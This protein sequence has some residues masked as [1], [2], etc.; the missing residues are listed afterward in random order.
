MSALTLW[1]GYAAAVT[2]TLISVPQAWRAFRVGTA[3]VSAVTFQLFS[4]IALMWMAYGIYEN[5]VPITL[6][7]GVQFLAC[8]AVL[9]ACRRGGAGW[10]HLV[11]VALSTAVLAAV[12][13]LVFGIPAMIWM[14]IAV[15]VGLRMP[16]LISALTER[17]V[18]GIS[19][20]TWW[21]AVA[22]NIFSFA[23]GLGNHDPR[24]MTACILNG[25]SSYAIILAVQI[26]RRSH[27]QVA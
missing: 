3:G 26:R 20:G 22:T 14:S 12:A 6:S 18:V 2:T 8:L 9:T 25:T 23:Y 21:M 15:S 19:L 7:N 11:P 16:Q 27:P 10:A 17:E 24:L 5:Y 13:A 1:A 4:G